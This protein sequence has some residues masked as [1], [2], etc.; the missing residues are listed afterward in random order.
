[1]ALS[2]SQG[3]KASSTLATIVTARNGDTLSPVT[4][5]VVA[6]AGDV[7]WRRR[8]NGNCSHREWRQIVAEKLRLQLPGMA[9][10][11]AGVDEA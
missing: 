9:T 10:I 8:E 11:V 3:H 1:M 7:E 5:T 4:T 2:H 6:V